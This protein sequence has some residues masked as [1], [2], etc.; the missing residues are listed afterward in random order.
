MFLSPIT[1]VLLMDA[2]VLKMRFPPNG[3]HARIKFRTDAAGWALVDHGT[4]N[5]APMRL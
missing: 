3:D 5:M 4:P 1:P 2:E